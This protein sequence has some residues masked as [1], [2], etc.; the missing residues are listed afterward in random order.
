MNFPTDYVE[1]ERPAPRQVQVNVAEEAS[2]DDVINE[3]CI[4]EVLDNI[5][6]TDRILSMELLEIPQQLVTLWR[7]FLEL[8]EEARN[9]GVEK[10][11]SFLVE[12]VP[13]KVTGMT[14][15]MIEPVSEMTDEDLGQSVEV[16]REGTARVPTVKFEAGQLMQWPDIKSDGVMIV[17]SCKNRRCLRSVLYGAR[18][19]RCP[20]Q[21]SLKCLPLFLPGGGGGVVAAAAP[22]AVVEAVTSRVSVLPVVGGDLLTGLS[23]AAGVTDQLFLGSGSSLDKVGH[24]AGQSGVRMVPV[25]PLPVLREVRDIMF[26]WMRP[27]AVLTSQYFLSDEEGDLEIPLRINGGRASL[28]QAQGVWP[29]ENRWDGHLILD[30]ICWLFRWLKIP[31]LSPR[32]GLCELIENYKW[33]SCTGIVPRSIQYP[34]GNLEV[35]GSPCLISQEET[36]GSVD[37]KGQYDDADWFNENPNR[38]AGTVVARTDATVAQYCS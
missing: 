33:K 1:I 27:V 18:L 12:E 9:S 13:P 14:R 30:I 21:L 19:S 35:S 15:P 23:A 36:T 10:K 5:K 24:G 4:Y 6:T 25:E 2:T 17:E 26:S 16:H 37:R 38:A 8:A 11:Q 28:Q 7:G 32:N 29:T 20:W 34:G 31:K 22:L 3:Q